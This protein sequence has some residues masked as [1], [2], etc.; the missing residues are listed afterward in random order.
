MRM[1][2]ARGGVT[3]AVQ[4]RSAAFALAAGLALAPAAS[5]SDPLDDVADAVRDFTLFE[6]PDGNEVC[7]GSTSKGGPR[8]KERAAASAVLNLARL[9]KRAKV[10][11][12]KARADRTQRER[13]AKAK[14]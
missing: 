4:A 3:R 11:E 8:A 2:E 10:A 14:R 1:N 13:R 7:L 12:R 6:T 5:A 9:Q